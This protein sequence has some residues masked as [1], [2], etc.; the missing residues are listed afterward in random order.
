MAWLE[1]LLGGGTA[2]AAASLG[3]LETTTR[4]VSGIASPWAPQDVALQPFVYEDIWGTT[5]PV[6]RAQAMTVPA[7]VAARSI[8][9]GELAHVPLRAL[10]GEEMVEPQPQWLARTNSIA[11]PWSRMARTLDDW[12]FY[13]DALWATTRGA[14]GF[15]LDAQYVARDLWRL[16]DAFEIELLESRSP[17]RWRKADALEVVYLPGP[18]EGLLAVASDTIRGALDIERAWRIQARTPLPGLLLQETEDNGMTPDEMQQWVSAVAAQRRKDDGAVMGLPKRITATFAPSSEPKLLVEGRNAIKLDIAN[19][20]NLNPAML[21]AALPKASLNYE[22]Q[23]GTRQEF[24]QRLSYWTAPLE[25]RLSQDD[26][27]PHGQRV[28]FDFNPT[29]HPAATS[30]GPTVED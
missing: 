25:D 26:I 27:V 16:N 14:D 5:G 15:P 11:G 2:Y 1:R 7:V 4:A 23:E 9:L 3:V 13:G 12:L 22:T 19:F 8:I 30:T 17:E 10:R 29:P 18:F 28:R 6:T 24:T 20:T 21:G